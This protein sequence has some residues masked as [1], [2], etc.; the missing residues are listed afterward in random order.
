MLTLFSDIKKEGGQLLKKRGEKARVGG[1]GKK[2][3]LLFSQRQ[4]EKRGKKG[5]ERES[6]MER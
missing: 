1:E 4:G 3:K 5:I 2:K 6:E